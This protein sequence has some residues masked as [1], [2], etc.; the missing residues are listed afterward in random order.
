LRLWRGEPVADIDALVAHP[1]VVGLAE[2]RTGAAVLLADVAE[3]VGHH[4]RSLPHLTALAERHPLDERLHA[5]LMLALAAA[6]QQAA[7]LAVYDAVEHR[8]VTDLGVAPGPELDAY[9]KRV[10]RQ[11]WTV[12]SAIPVPAQLPPDVYG[13]AGRAAEL[14]R[15]DEILSGAADEPTAVVIS[16]LS[17]T[18]GVGK[19]ALTVHWAH[20]V[21]GEFPDGQLYVNLRGFDPVGAALT[22]S[23]ALRGFLE[24]LGVPP[25]QLPADLEAQTGLY[26][27]LLTGKRVLVVLD[28]A[29]DAAQ[30]RP[31]LPGAPGCLVVVTSRDRLAGLVVAEGAQPL[32]LDLL[33]VAESWQL[34]SRRIGADRMSADP[35][36]TDEIIIQCARLPLALAVVAAQAAGRP[37]FPLRELAEQLREDSLRAF[38]HGDLST[39]IAAVFSWSYRALDPVAARL[40]RLLG[41]HPGPEVSAAAAASLAGIPLDKARAT[42]ADLTRVHLLNERAPG[43]Y[44]FH[45]LLR[46]YAAQLAERYDSEAD[47]HAAVHRM[48]DHYLH[49][50]HAAATLIN[51]HRDPPSLAPIQPLVVAE[52]PTDPRHALAWYLAEHS[53]LL[54]LVRLAANLALDGH[55]WRLAWALADYLDRQGHWREVEA[56]QSIGLAAAQRLN[57]PLGEAHTRR[58]L[59]RFCGRHGRY[60][61][62]H[63]HLEAALN[64]HEALG[65]RVGMGHTYGNIFAVLE[66]QGRYREA[67]DVALRSLEH[68]QAANHK[69][70]V[71]L[72]NN[73]IGYTYT[74][75]GDF[76]Q[77]LAYCT[78]AHTALREIGFVFGEAATCDSMGYI[79]HQMGDHE[80]ALTWYRQA[81][82]LYREL[83]ERRGACTTLTRLGDLYHVTGD[84]DGASAAWQEALAILDL[85]GPQLSSEAAEVRA[86]LDRL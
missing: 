57:D 62:A 26:R 61:E 32:N 82:E 83:G 31:L 27:S 47:R 65:D 38:A 4:E 59:A 37:D 5:R 86:K 48:V 80:Q 64:L 60:D 22:P 58:D 52:P 78:R 25:Q 21:A 84:V 36:A 85:L 30:V 75:L 50:S 3:L 12:R 19:T 74:R 29:R 49:T 23:E 51:V 79:H 17:G 10:L 14:K 76:E 11:Q 40:F 71:A 41:L 1:L 43:R 69:S 8:L 35:V 73:N 24:S 55:A 39:D 72:V 70:G 66:W 56:T 2:E 63:A 46:A 15:L 7:A 53:V 13:F 9:R 45:D 68:Y 54:A 16:A 28:N 81:L 67:L 34:L 20:S 42:L 18:A 77:A 44:S 6:G 33:T